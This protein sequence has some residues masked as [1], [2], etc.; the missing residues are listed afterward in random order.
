M[1][2]SHTTTIN[3]I[4][5]LLFYI[6]KFIFC[7]KSYLEKVSLYCYICATIFCVLGYWKCSNKTPMPMQIWTGFV[8]AILRPKILRNRLGVLKQILSA[9]NY[10]FISLYFRGVP[11]IQEKIKA[12]VN[13]NFWFTPY[14]KPDLLTAELF[15]KLCIAKRYVI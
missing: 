13:I 3:I 11:S 14:K 6:E 9:M 1:R 15:F 2:K 5:L 4:L 7:Q 8:D 12:L 10:Y